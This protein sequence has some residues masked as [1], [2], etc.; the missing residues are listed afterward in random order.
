MILLS[1]TL[2]K[3]KLTN[4][5]RKQTSGFLGLRKKRLTTMRHEISFLSNNLHWSGSYTD[6]YITQCS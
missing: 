3:M 5:D 4:G 2:E 1:E 6:L